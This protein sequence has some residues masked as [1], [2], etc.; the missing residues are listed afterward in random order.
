VADPDSSGSLP[1]KLMLNLTVCDAT[2]FRAANRILL[3]HHA[4]KPVLLLKKIEDNVTYQS[5]FDFIIVV[6]VGMVNV[7]MTA[8]K[9][10]DYDSGL[11]IFGSKMDVVGFHVW[12]TGIGN[13]RSSEYSYFIGIFAN[14][15]KVWLW[16]SVVE[17]LVSSR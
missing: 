8:E 3:S 16:S 11:T 14:H 4:C 10:Q 1:R 12:Y 2:F 7:V 13:F 6:T 9:N 5:A 15:R 17:K